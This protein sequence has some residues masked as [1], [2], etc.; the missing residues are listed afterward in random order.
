MEV[1]AT[2]TDANITNDS[3]K[4][5]SVVM[6]LDIRNMGRD[7]RHAGNIWTTPMSS[8]Q[9]TIGSQSKQTA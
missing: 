7:I 3:G 9:S 1:D 4:D 5:H 2:F 6:L 8:R